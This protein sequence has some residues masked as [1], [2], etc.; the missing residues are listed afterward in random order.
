MDFFLF[1][2]SRAQSV[3][4]GALDISCWKRR[5][6]RRQIK[7]IEV[8]L[9]ILHAS[10]RIRCTNLPDANTI[11]QGRPKM[12]IHRFLREICDLYEMRNQ[13]DEMFVMGTVLERH[14]YVVFEREAREP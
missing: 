13:R 7:N 3:E 8:S 4:A 2:L 9:R 6:R 14:P 11:Q 10:R 12:R 1:Q 5:T